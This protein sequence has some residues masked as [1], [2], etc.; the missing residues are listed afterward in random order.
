MEKLATL[1]SYFLKAAIGLAIFTPVFFLIAALGTKL[2]IWG[3]MFG[4]VKMTIG[5]GPKIMM[6]TF[7]IS[8]IALFLAL[9]VK[10]R[11]D[12]LVALLCLAVPMVGIGFAKNVK[13]K[14]GKLPPI[15]DIT[16][17]TQNPPTFTQVIIERRAACSNSLEYI[18]TTYGKKKTLVSAGQVNAYPDIRTLVF[19][20]SADALYKRA[21]STVNTMGWK[22]ASSSE[23]TGTIEAT[24]SSFWFGFTDDVAIRIR[25]SE[26]GGS[27]LDIRS[28]SCVGRSDIGANAARIRKFRDGLG[29]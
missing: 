7:V 6:L 27:L 25:P 16:T 18:G 14:A 9:I 22:L 24:D 26:G 15:H 12:W 2:G 28:V 21:L 3:W 4:F 11:K 8:L 19:T 23:D 5:Y 1:K 20:D 17:D 13:A 29:G 10:P